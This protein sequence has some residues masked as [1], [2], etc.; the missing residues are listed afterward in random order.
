MQFRE[1]SFLN[2]EAFSEMHDWFNE[3][4]LYWL[5]WELGRDP[6]SIGDWEYI[7]KYQ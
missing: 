1:V 5:E 6:S 3:V 7:Y 2:E 4:N